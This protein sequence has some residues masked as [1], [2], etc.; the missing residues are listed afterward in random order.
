MFFL[1]RLDR[2][3]PGMGLLIGAN[4]P[5][6]RI[7]HANP[8][9]GIAEQSAFRDYSRPFWRVSSALD[10]SIQNTV[11]INR[12]NINETVKIDCFNCDIEGVER[13]FPYRSFAHR[14]CVKPR[15]L[16]ARLGATPK[17]RGGHYRD[18]TCCTRARTGNKGLSIREDA[19]NAR[20]STTM[21]TAYWIPG[22]WP[23]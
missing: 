20:S 8:T 6:I 16:S 18:Y 23:P 10:S 11:N 19:A 9:D 15:R 7:S 22:G 1:Q 3:A 5:V 2:R 4:D 21:K 14:T 13:D 12:R 17:G